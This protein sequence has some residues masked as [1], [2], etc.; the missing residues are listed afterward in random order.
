MT[1]ELIEDGYEPQEEIQQEPETP[2]VDPIAERLER[3]EQAIMNMAQR[4][5]PA[6]PQVVAPPRPQQS[7]PG[8]GD[9]HRRR[10]D[11]HERR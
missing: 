11:D 4:P 3:M 5:Q 1:D 8:G 6:A 10:D 2:A 7:P 9:P